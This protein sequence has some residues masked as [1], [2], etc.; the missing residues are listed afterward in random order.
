VQVSQ[1]LNPRRISRSLVT[2]LILTLFTTIAPPTLFPEL[3]SQ[4]QANPDGL[5]A[6]YRADS[7]GGNDPDLASPF[8]T[9]TCL[10]TKLQ[11]LTADWGTGGPTGGTSSC[12]IDDFTAYYTG[13]ILGPKTG[14]VNF[15]GVAD[16]VLFVRINGVSVVEKYLNSGTVSGSFN[17]TSGVAY[18][19]Q[20]WF[21]EVGGSAAFALNWDASGSA[22]VVGS[23]YLASTAA[24]LLTSQYQTGNCR[25]GSSAECPAYSPQEIYN[26]YGTTADGNYWIMTGGSPSYQYVLMDRSIDSGG[27]ILGM[28]ANKTSTNYDWEDTYRWTTHSIDNA[29]PLEDLTTNPARISGT[30]TGTDGKY[31]AFNTVY[32]QKIRA[33]F[34]EFAASTYGGRYTTNNNYGFMWEENLS[35]LT[36]GAG[37][38]SYTPAN[39]SLATSANCTG[40]S[41]KVLQDLFANSKRCLFRTPAYTH[42]P[43]NNNTTSYDP[44]G[45]NLFASQN[46]FAW[47]GINY[48]QPVAV[49]SPSAYHHARF[50]FGWNENSPSTD[51]G[52]NDVAAGI[53]LFKASTGSNNWPTGSYVGCCASQTGQN[54]QMAFEIYLR[55]S[56]PSL[57]APTNLRATPTSSTAVR[58]SWNAPPSTSP[59][60][61][62]VQYKTNSAS[63][64]SNISTVR[65]LDP[66]SNPTASIT[67]LAAGTIY[68]Y[69]VL[70]RT[71][72]MTTKLYDTNSS[73]TPA[74]IRSGIEDQAIDSAFNFGGNQFFGSSTESSF[75][76]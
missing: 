25:I 41:T 4:S 64:D 69:R 42:T 58:L 55:Q 34:P 28:K 21:H 44:I 19:I 39:Y 2:V 13:Y 46:Y 20:I 74:Y 18:P 8:V 11:T 36:S 62:V 71:I 9:N 50:G 70:A 33:V 29:S 53:G 37:G 22:A 68:N 24:N 14:T 31:E 12:G 1:A 51:E 30:G 17:F 47:W 7:T 59:V 65:I 73:S 32:A 52:S 76:I 61:Y 60:E 49:G 56:D 63:W 67:G 15:S 26:L 27:W 43:A 75:D 5:N 3:I 35:S 48:T 45:N 54:K 72:D 40:I 57:G 6:Y 66:G 10:T 38:G 16:D 23:S